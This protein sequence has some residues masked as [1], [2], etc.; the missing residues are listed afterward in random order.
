MTTYTI[1]T[2]SEKFPQRGKYVCPTTIR[3]MI[4]A[5]QLPSS[6]IVSIV[7]GQ[8]LIEVQSYSDLA[9]RIENA[10]NKARLKFKG[11]NRIVPIEIVAECALAY[12]I[13]FEYLC[14]IINGR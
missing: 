14:K 10:C 3:R 1:T 11:E 2:Y 8:Y 6:H 5:N 7:G 9:T 13:N 12:D 4:M